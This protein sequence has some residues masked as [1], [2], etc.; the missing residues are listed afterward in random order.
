MLPEH[1]GQTGKFK[2]ILNYI[3]VILVNTIPH[4]PHTPHRGDVQGI[5]PYLNR[6]GNTCRAGLVCCGGAAVLDAGT[7][8]QSQSIFQDLKSA[9]V[10]HDSAKTICI[11]V[12][13]RSIA[14]KKDINSIELRV[15]Y[16]L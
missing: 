11:I 10:F 16:R 1:A 3:F 12:F 4:T 15:S 2:V 9:K 6:E 14:A 8:T 5:R 7:Y 13:V